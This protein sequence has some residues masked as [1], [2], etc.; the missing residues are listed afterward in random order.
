MARGLEDDDSE[1]ALASA[2]F[3][4]DLNL[5]ISYYEAG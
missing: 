2:H 5:L 3:E 4:R 1:L